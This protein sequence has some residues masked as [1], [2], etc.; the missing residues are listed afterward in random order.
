MENRLARLSA[1]EGYKMSYT[2]R[3]MNWMGARLG[4]PSK[5]CDLSGE[6]EQIRWQM[7]VQGHDG[8]IWRAAFAEEEELRHYVADPKR[9]IARRK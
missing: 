4:T 9:F 2:Q 7:T 1:S 6:Q 8:Q 3:M 5:R